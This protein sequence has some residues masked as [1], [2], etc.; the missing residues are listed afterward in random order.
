MFIGGGLLK[1]SRRGLG[2][3][4]RWGVLEALRLRLRFEYSKKERAY[5]RSYPSVLY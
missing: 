4:S 3:P 5:C 2:E 1:E